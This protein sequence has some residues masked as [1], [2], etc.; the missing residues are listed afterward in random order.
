MPNAQSGSLQPLTS[1][2]PIQESSAFE[3]SV[4]DPNQSSDS[5]STPTTGAAPTAGVPPPPVVKQVAEESGGS[6]SGHD[7]RSPAS[8]VQDQTVNS[9]SPTSHQSNTSSGFGDTSLSLPTPQQQHQP[10]LS[11]TSQPFYQHQYGYV[12]LDMSGYSQ[13]QNIYSNQG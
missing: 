6:D 3:S 13:Y 12:P 5:T 9:S 1:T 10:F 11:Y 2:S 8:V 7:V 4:S